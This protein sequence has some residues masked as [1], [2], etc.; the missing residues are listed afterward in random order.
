MPS[1]E[2]DGV[3]SV[4][5]SLRPW[6][7]RWQLVRA[8]YDNKQMPL[9]DAPPGLR[10]FTITGDE[11]QVS[12]DTVKTLTA[13]GWTDNFFIGTVRT[14]PAGH[15]RQFQIR[16]KGDY[17]LT[18]L[19]PRCGL[20]EIRD[21]QLVWCVHETGFFNAS[22]PEDE[23]KPT[24][25]AELSAAPGSHCY[26]Y[27]F[28][29]ADSVKSDP[30]LSSPDDK[31]L[32]TAVEAEPV[33]PIGDAAVETAGLLVAKLSMG[34]DIRRETAEHMI[35]LLKR[36]GI[37]NIQTV[38]GLD[39]GLSRVRISCPENI[40]FRDIQKIQAAIGDLNTGFKLT[41]DL[42]KPESKPANVGR[43]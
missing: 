24:V 13:E 29:Q 42:N 11:L 17:F 30:V 1:K 38:S 37:K 3:K 9:P 31:G 18:P 10:G 14:A 41:V 20:F 19:L 22:Q 34:P 2:Q 25:P 33:S 21:G 27:V 28:K 6:Q 5:L 4:P 35:N 39:D 43:N 7:G 23:Y 36:L 26:L 32:S 12:E 15:R 16:M 8:E 40:T